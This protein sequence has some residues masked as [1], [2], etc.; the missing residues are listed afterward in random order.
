M[1]KL[2]VSIAAVLVLCL[3]A[4]ASA[5]T[6]I[7]TAV[8]IGAWRA[9]E[10][11]YRSLMG[12]PDAYSHREIVL[13]A[14]C[15]IDHFPVP[16]GYPTLAR[17]IACESGWGPEAVSPSGS[18]RGLMQLGYDEFHS[19]VG[20]MS[21]PVKRDWTN[22]RSNLLAGVRLAHNVGWGPWACA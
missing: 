12:S 20:P 10:C 1:H 17:I 13:T 6:E 15:A 4:P 7:G 22:P 5:Q 9:E 21:W 14:R 8:T 2:I 19:N 18:Y 16:G 3:A 11:R